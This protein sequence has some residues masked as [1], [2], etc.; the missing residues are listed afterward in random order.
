MET[1]ESIERETNLAALGLD[2]LMRME[3]ATDIKDSF[4]VALDMHLVTNESKFGDLCDMVTLPKPAESTIPTP[5][6][7]VNPEPHRRK[8]P[9]RRAHDGFP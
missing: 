3:L 6:P 7:S 5:A 2:S 1:S 9:I 4:G 8:V